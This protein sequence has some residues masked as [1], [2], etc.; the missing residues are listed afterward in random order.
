MENQCLDGSRR[1]VVEVLIDGETAPLGTLPA[2][3]HR[4]ERTFAGTGLPRLDG[5]AIGYVR[6]VVAEV[7]DSN[8]RRC[9]NNPPHLV[10]GALSSNL[11]T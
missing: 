11:G 6:S 1:C 4:M 9:N 2:K 10:I 8:A 7:G 5:Q 3:F